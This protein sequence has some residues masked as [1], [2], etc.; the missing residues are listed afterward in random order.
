MVT[1]TGKLTQPF[2]ILDVERSVEH[3]DGVIAV[4]NSIEVL[5]V[6]RFDDQLRVGLARAIYGSPHFRQY[7]G[8]KRPIYIIVEQGHVTLEGVVLGD[9]DQA[10]AQAI[11]KTSARAFSVVIDLKTTAKAQLALENL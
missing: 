8:V 11:A 6:S 3:V 1:L 5:P 4:E 10:L 7:G 9:T 2:T